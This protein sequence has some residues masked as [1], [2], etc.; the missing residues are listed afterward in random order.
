MKTKANEYKNQNEPITADQ[1][2]EEAQKRVS[3]ISREFTDGFTFLKKHQK[4][5]TF[6]GSARLQKSDTYYKQAKS[7]AK[8]ISEKLGYAIVSGGGPGI[9]Q[10]AN[11]GAYKAGGDSL[12]ITICLPE[13]Q[14]TNDYT[15]EEIDFHYFFSR[16]VVLSFSAE[17]YV[18]F[19]GGYGT[20]DELF[21]ILTL[22]QTNKIE[23]VPIILVG[24]DFWKGFNTFV[25][26]MLKKNGLIDETDTNLYTISDDETEILSIIENAKVRQGVRF[27]EPKP[28]K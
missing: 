10:A 16:K 27:K 6:F 22:V 25:E 24:S 26:E 20:F 2:E 4:S 15:T 3:K 11:E 28:K 5:V 1:L 23:K 21:E 19:P 8:R 18:Y 17:A 13:E 9:M 14:T 7:L 12:G